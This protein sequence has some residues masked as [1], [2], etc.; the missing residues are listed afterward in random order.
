MLLKT[1]NEGSFS[2]SA[3]WATP[4][5]TVWIGC[6]YFVLLCCSY[7]LTFDF[8]EPM[9]RTY[10]CYFNKLSW[11]TFDFRTTAPARLSGPTRRRVRTR[12]RVTGSQPAS[13]RITPT[14]GTTATS[15]TTKPSSCK[16]SW[17]KLRSI[18]RK[19]LLLWLIFL[20]LNLFCW[21]FLQILCELSLFRPKLNSQVSIFLLLIGNQQCCTY[22][23]DLIK[24]ALPR[25]R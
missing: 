18:D 2:V 16:K 20:A 14:T 25:D 4:P 7:L 19:T 22:S 3:N 23:W 24:V 5:V 13:S 21:L 8:N 10:R 12:W 15:P 6:I 9:P 17:S 11:P 1:L